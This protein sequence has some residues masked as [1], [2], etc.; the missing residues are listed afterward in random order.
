MVYFL[1]YLKEFTHLLKYNTIHLQNDST[2][3]LEITFHYMLEDRLSLDKNRMVNLLVAFLTSIKDLVEKFL[4]ASFGTRLWL[5]KKFLK[6]LI[7]PKNL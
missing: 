3:R 2:K 5:Q 4:N 6:L 7:A 1:P